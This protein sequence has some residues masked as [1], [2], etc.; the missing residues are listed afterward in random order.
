MLSITC[1]DT[2][3]M[4]YEGSP[5]ITFDCSGSSSA[6]GCFHSLRVD[7]ARQYAEHR[8]TCCWYGRSHADIRR[9][10]G[11]KRRGDVRVH[12]ERL[13]REC[14]RRFRRRYGDGAEQAFDNGYVRQAI[15]TRRMRERAISIWTVAASGAP[16]GSVYA[17]AWSRDAAVQPNT[18]KF[19]AGTDGP[20]PVVRRSGRK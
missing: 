12:A 2:E 16:S 19:V 6:C 10:G 18:D 7:A 13:C 4:P 9:S 1:T 15:P 14:G 3:Y 17:Y 5:D 20:T 8:Q 11:S